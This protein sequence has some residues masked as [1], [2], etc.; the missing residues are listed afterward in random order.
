MII[1]T[2]AKLTIVFHIDILLTCPLLKQVISFLQQTKKKMKQRLI[3]T[4]LL[5]TFNLICSYTQ[6]AFDYTLVLEPV[7]IDNLNGLHSYAFGQNDGRWLLIGGRKDGLHA[8]QPFNSF[9]ESMNNTDIYVV[10]VEAKQFWSAPLSSLPS[11]IS[12]QLQATNLNFFQDDDSLYIIGGYAYSQTANNHITFNKLTSVQVSPLIDAIVNGQAIAPFFKQIEDTLFAVTGGQLGKMSDTFYLVGGHRFNGRYNPMGNPTY[13]QDYTNQIRKFKINN[14]GNQLSISDI[15]AITDPVHLRRRDYNLLAQVF[16]DGSFG[17][18]ISSGVFQQNI[19]LPFLYPVDMKET[20][21]EPHT[22]FNQYLNNYHSAHANLYDSIANE[23][24]SIFFGGISQYYYTNGNLV[25]DNFVPFVNT[26][27]RLTRLADNTFLEF[28]FDQQMPALLG[29]S[30]EFIPA[31]TADRYPNDVIKL[32][33]FDQDTT[34]IGYVYGGIYSPSLNPFTNNQTNTTAAS[35][36]IY[37]VKLIKGATVGS[38]EI[39]G[40]NPYS[41]DFYPNPV[42]SSF[43][44]KFSLEKPVDVNYYITNISGQLMATGDINGTKAGQNIHQIF[45]QSDLHAQTLNVTLVFDNRFFCSKKLV[46]E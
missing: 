45:C 3:L 23:M 28:Q 36:T 33:R 12:E 11:N 35:S 16:P 14:S 22:N 30:A 34:V 7:Q 19:D 25:Q 10:D 42:S 31:Q 41:F 27:S 8:R 29:A 13:T 32:H 9:P 1:L 2:T 6:S 15:S 18:T 43:Q 21:I 39:N 5:L 17:Y 37:A 20:G 26:I 24:H 4:T 44:V 38:T 46:R 40:N